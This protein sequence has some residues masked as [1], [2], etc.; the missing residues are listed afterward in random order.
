MLA[1]S[2]TLPSAELEGRG[3]RGEDPLGDALSPWPWSHPR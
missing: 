3:Q 1:E 2:V